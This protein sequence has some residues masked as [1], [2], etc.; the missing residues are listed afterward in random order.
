MT[1]HGFVLIHPVTG[2]A[3]SPAFAD[4]AA[5]RKAGREMVRKLGHAVNV[6][7][8]VNG[9]HVAYSAEDTAAVCSR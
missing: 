5:V 4:K 6:F 8:T 3:L 7:R 9:E 1:Q 2:A